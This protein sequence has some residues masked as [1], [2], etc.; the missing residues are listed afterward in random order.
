MHLGDSLGGYCFMNEDFTTPL[1]L[2]RYI[3]YKGITTEIFHSRS[4]ILEINSKSGLYPLYA[5]YNI[6][7]TRLKEAQE[8]YGEVNRATALMLWDRTLEENIFVVCKTPM[9]R[10][11]TL[12]TL[13]GFRN[14]AVHAKYYPDLIENIT[15]Q[16]DSVVNMLRSGKRFWKINNDENMKIDA[17]IGNPPYQLTS[18][19]TSDTPVYHLFIDLASQLAPRIT[20]ITPARYLFNAG[21]TPKEWN[22][23]I[24]NDKHFKVVN[25][26]ADSTHVFPTVDIKG[27]VAVMLRDTKSDFGKISTFTAYPELTSIANKVTYPLGELSNIIYPQNKFNLEEIYDQCPEARKI[28]GSNGMERRLT[29]PIFKQLSLFYTEQNDRRTYKILGLI[30]NKRCYRWIDRRYIETHPNLDKYK[31]IVPKSNGSGAIGE[32]LSTPLIGEPLIGVTQTFLTIGA[33][34]TRAEAE[35][36]L[37]YIK[38]KFARTMLGIL[39]ATQDNPKET[40]R[41][42]PLQ[43]FTEVSD[44]D[45]SQSIANIDRQLYLKYGLEESEIAFIEE[46]VRA[47]E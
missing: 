25:Y 16:P 30:N 29:T 11:I 43:D 37:K 23:K 38:T 13:R 31:V 21:K 36:C 4:V 28:I 14:V 35:A 17:I 8:R 18:E 32:V 12:R 15:R 10:Y 47:M 39:K 33:F 46:K 44:I 34:D 40:W 20:L 7:R 2:P 24:L 1:D 45:W 5:A 19:N 9:A 3:E 26:W 6:Y 42:V 41:L 27:G 22:S